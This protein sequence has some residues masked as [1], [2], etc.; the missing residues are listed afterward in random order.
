[1]RYLQYLLLAA[2]VTGSTSLIAQVEFRLAYMKA[3]HGSSPAT[4]PNDQL[5]KYMSHDPIFAVADLKRAKAFLEDGRASIELEISESARLSFNALA[6]ANIKNQTGG[7]FEEHVGLA[8]VV[9][10]KPTQVVQGIFRPLPKRTLWW[11]P[12]DDRLPPDEQLKQAKSL[13]EQINKQRPNKSVKNGSPTA[14]AY[15]QRW[16][17]QQACFG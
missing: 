7:S 16:A 5:F 11:S 9:D 4:F 15:V 3:V 8:V 13:A 6:R 10:G 1:M 14:P 12:A 2:L 17:T